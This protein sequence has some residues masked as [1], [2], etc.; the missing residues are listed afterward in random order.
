MLKK[1][2]RLSSDFEF[3]V[4][5]KYGRYYESPLTHTYFLIPKNYQGPTKIGIVVSNKFSK[6]A[7]ERNRVK[8][9]YRK[10]V[11]ENFEKLNKGDLWIVIHPKFGS[12]NKTYEEINTDFNK[13]L[14]KASFSN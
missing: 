2:N 11:E 13:I 14:Q 12:L 9:I 8:R 3:N 7:V 5:R 4:S 1:E 10:V 6:K